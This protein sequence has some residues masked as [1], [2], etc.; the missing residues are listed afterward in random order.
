MFLINI[1]LEY[2]STN[3]QTKDSSDLGKTNVAQKYAEKM[4]FF[5][6]RFEKKRSIVADGGNSDKFHERK[7]AR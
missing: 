4:Y 3:V 1:D 6:T 7:I 5:L 2:A